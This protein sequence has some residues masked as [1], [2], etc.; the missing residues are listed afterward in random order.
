MATFGELQSRVADELGGRD[1]L[2]VPATG[3]TLS[4]V[5]LAIIDAIQ[6]WEEEPFYFNE[7]RD[8]PA[9]TTVL[10]Q[11]FYTSSDW[12]NVVNTGHITSMTVVLSGTRY[13][14]NPRSMQ[15]MDEYA[16]TSTFTGCPTDFCYFNQQ[17]RFYPIP[18]AVYDVNVVR[19]KL[20][21]TLSA[22]SDTNVWTEDA[23]ALTRS[24]AKWFICRDVTLDDAGAVRY[25]RTAR[26]MHDGLKGDSFRRA[27][28]R[29][30][31]ATQF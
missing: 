11:E 2:L 18:N 1:D 12:A 26:E 23:E 21:T 19:T 5:A 31:R 17:I 27:S 9:F 16:I 15:W 6:Y 20:F 25:E 7:I 28:N 13:I 22:A 10:G 24:T 4:P 3:L 30:V 29:R 14:V 8:A